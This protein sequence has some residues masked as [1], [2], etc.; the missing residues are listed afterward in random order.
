MYILFTK[1]AFDSA[2]S[3]H[4]EDFHLPCVDDVDYQSSTNV[5]QAYWDIPDSSKHYIQDVHWAVE[6]RAP[7]AGRH[8]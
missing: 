6:I 5:L 3:H 1:T 7:M 8:S 2:T 4:M